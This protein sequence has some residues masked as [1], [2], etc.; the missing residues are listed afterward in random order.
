MEKQKS[1][2]LVRIFELEKDERVDALQKALSTSLMEESG[3]VY[4]LENLEGMCEGGK[5][6]EGDNKCDRT[7]TFPGSCC[8]EWDQWPDIL[9]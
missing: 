4:S 3:F 1:E 7:L 9:S 2:D 6:V 5:R 8:S